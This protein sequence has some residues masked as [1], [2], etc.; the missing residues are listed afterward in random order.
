MCKKFA[1]ERKMIVKFL[2]A[3]VAAICF[4]PSYAV[5]D[6]YGNTVPTKNPLVY[7][8]Q[9]QNL[10]GGAKVI[11]P[12]E[13]QYSK[14]E[15]GTYSSTI[16][17]A[18]IPGKYD[19]WYK[20][21]PQDKEKQATGPTKITASISKKS[22]TIVWSDTSEVVYDGNYHKPTVTLDGIVGEDKVEAKVNEYINAGNYEIT[23]A[24][25][26][27]DAGRYTLEGVSNPTISYYID[28]AV[29]VAGKNFTAPTAK[30]NLVYDG[31]E[32]ELIKAGQSKIDGTFVYGSSADD[33]VP[34]IPTGKNP[35]KY[36][37]KYK[38][39]SN[40]INYY[41]S[42][43]GTILV[44]I[45]PRTIYLEWTNNTP[46][47][48][49]GQLQSPTADVNKDLSTI[50]EEDDVNIVVTGQEKNVGKNYFVKASLTG[51]NANKYE[52]SNFKVGYEIDPKPLTVN[53]SKTEL[54]Y[55][56]KAQKPTATLKSGDVIEGEEVGVEVGGEKT[57]VGNYTATATLTGA[58][59]GN[60]IISEGNES[61][62]F[63]ISQ[64]ESSVKTAPAA[65]ANWTYD[66]KSYALVTAG[67]VGDI[68]GA[69]EYALGET[70]AFT[71]TIPTA[72]EAGSYKV[73]SQFVPTDTKNYKTLAFSSASVI[74]AKKEVTVEWGE[75]ALTYNGA[76]QAPTA[77]LKG[78]VDDVTLVISGEKKE[79]GTGYTATATLSGDNKD[80]YVISDE[81]ASI[82]FSI[83]PS[84]VID[85]TAPTAKTGLTYNGLDQA[86]V[87]AGVVG[88]IEGHFEYALGEDGEFGEAIPKAT[89]AKT[90]KVGYKFVSENGGYSSSDP[91]YVSV[92]IAK[93]EVTV[94]WGETT[95]TYNGT[96]QAPTA[97]LN[98]VVTGDDVTA[99]V[100]GEQSEVGTNY[101]ATASLS[102]AKK[103]NYVITGENTTT[104]SII[105][106][107]VDDYIVPTAKEN[108]IYNGSDQE[109][110]TAG[111][112]GSIKGHFEYA[113]GEE[114][115]FGETLPK[116]TD[117]KTYKVGYK[118]IPDDKDN[119]ISSEPLFIS[120]KIAQLERSLKWSDTVL[121]YNGNEQKPTA[122]LK[123]VLKG[124]VVSVIVDGA[125]TKVNTGYIA[126]AAEL[127]GTDAKNYVIVGDVTKKFSIIKS[128]KKDYTAPTAIENLVYSGKK[129]ELLKAGAEG[130]IK[131]SFKYVLGASTEV[132]T[133]PSVKEADEYSVGYRFEPE[134]DGY[135]S[136]ELVY[137][138]AKI[139]KKDAGIKWGETELVYNGQEQKPSATL[140]GVIEGDEVSV[141]VKG[142]QTDVKEGYIAI[143]TLTGKDAKNYVISEANASTEFSIVSK[144][145]EKP[146]FTQTEFTYSGSIITFVENNTSLS[147]K[148]ESAAK[149]PDIYPVKIAPSYGNIWAD[150]TDDTISVTFRINKISVEKPEADTRSFVFN[151]TVQ[152]YNLAANT[153]YKI[154]GNKQK[155]AGNYV[156]TVSL[157]D[158]NHYEWSDNKNTEDKTYPFTISKG[159][160][161]LP[162]VDS[163]MTYVYDGNE[164]NFNITVAEGSVLADSNATGVDAGVYVRTVSL[165]MDENGGYEWDDNTTEPKTYKFVIKQQ[166]VII[167]EVS[168]RYF[169]YNGKPFTFVVPEDTATV[170]RYTIFKETDSEVGPGT[171]TDTV[172]LND[173]KNYMWSDNT[174]E[175]RLIV[176]TIGDGKIEKPQVNQVYTYTGEEII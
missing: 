19:V 8:G 58:D 137:I 95:L 119:Y 52:I 147:V 3:L 79:V 13:F 80:N 27:D 18:I 30:S 96:L 169:I 48:Y 23:A 133:V 7:N 45:A 84:S 39:V 21:V 101:T 107:G 49:N 120:V 124:D 75:T 1:S 59:K 130:N 41:D 44:E 135:M 78:A 51:E 14:E 12:G 149:E 115:V 164:K 126:T 33:L 65:V 90:Y 132:D 159:I 161:K 42:E 105:Q 103:E 73:K 152:T 26:G 47:R 94:E 111:V 35:G 116:A 134:D 97:T 127:S 50:V 113:L 153:A 157:V 89:D 139:A 77:T 145:I 6:E 61:T 167:P 110:I 62:A 67:K 141:S 109:L 162:S 100:T 160:V 29:P 11:E 55:N 22:L 93:K 91:V 9:E 106:S 24:L 38:F 146:V 15:E 173:T 171:Y 74:V 112:A 121:V 66:G 165:D 172:R 108:L 129:Q 98:G 56:G 122:E 148:G 118:F 114:G 87:N 170:P 53:W 176:F 88:N 68:E 37:V 70:G 138:T 125:Q 43:I 25:S 143:A 31:T 16:P 163:V 64:A 174:V 5:V 83:S 86:L 32:Q 4:V 151:G 54:T 72:I 175:E 46:Y 57:D 154:S 82:K 34:E 76:S 71:S 155:L 117:A 168:E 144:K 92:T 81:T 40:S 36:S 20:F 104:Y 123:N 156:V 150:G 166:P 69:F 28:R 2:F 158:K 102:G 85:Y 17:T 60:Y 128:D 63:S 99:L 131:G 142:A 136:S 10:V 140:S